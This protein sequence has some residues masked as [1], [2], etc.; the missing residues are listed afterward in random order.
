MRVKLGLY[1]A[2]KGETNRFPRLLR[3]LALA[4][5]FNIQLVDGVISRV[6]K[7]FLCAIVRVEKLLI[8]PSK[9]CELYWPLD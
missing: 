5:L 7:T 9:S 2:L 4:S 6:L 1:K 3:W 8:D